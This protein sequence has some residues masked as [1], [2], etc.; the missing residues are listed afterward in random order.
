MK[1]NHSGSFT[2][3]L[4]RRAL[5]IIVASLFVPIL[6]AQELNPDQLAT[7]VSDGFTI[8]VVGDGFGGEPEVADHEPRASLR[9]AN[10]RASAA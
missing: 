4:C 1:R 9:G 2:S 7:T 10:G 8:A 5:L 6:A 3:L